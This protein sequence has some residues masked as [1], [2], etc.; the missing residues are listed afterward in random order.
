MLREPDEDD[1]SGLLA[2]CRKGDA[3][4][5]SE[6]VDRFQGYVYSIPRRMGLGEDDCADVFQTT[7]IALHRSLER[8]EAAAALPKWLGVTASREAVRLRRLKARNPASENVGVDERTLEDVL[9]DDERSAEVEAVAACE[10]RMIRLAVGKLNDRCAKLL[11]A[12]YLEDDPAYQEIS[13]RLGIPVGAIGPTRAR[14][15]DKLR[16]ELAEGGFFD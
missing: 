8:I 15:L 11:T 7:F 13:E 6:L 16:K 4:A 1:L 5:W 9:A 12:L 10:S 3:R 2:R 14:C